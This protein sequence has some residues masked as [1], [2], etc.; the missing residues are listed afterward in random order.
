M[1]YFK[2]TK[3]HV[4]IIFLLFSLVHLSIV[5]LNHYYYKTFTFDYGVYNFA[6]FDFAHLRVS[7]CPVYLAG[8]DITFLQDH[9]SLTLIFL[10]PLYWLLSPVFGTY[11]LLIIQWSLILLGGWATY[12]YLLLRFQNQFLAL[13]AL[14]V[15]FGLYG[16]Y[17]AYQND[18]NLVTMGSALVPLFFYFFEKRKFIAVY[19]LFL[20][21]IFNR[22]DFSLNLFFVCLMLAILYR[23]DQEQRRVALI[24]TVA[25]VLC[26]IVIFQFIIPALED[27]QKSFS[28]FNYQALG[29]DPFEAFV[30]ILSH[31]FDSIVLLV[32]NHTN[33][34]ENDWVK[35]RFYAV[36]ALSGGIFLF[37]RPV[38]LIALI[39]LIAKKMYNDDS[40][41]WSIESYHGV[42]VASILPILVFSAVS[43]IKFEGLKVALAA[44]S[45]F[46]TLSLTFYLVSHPSPIY[47]GVNKFNLFSSSFYQ[48]SCDK[49][50]WNSVRKKIPDSAVLSATGNVLPHLAFRK[51]IFYF[52]QI[53]EAD[54][55]CI[56]KT[57]S[58]YP[59][60]QEIFDSRVRELRE[61]KNWKIMMEEKDCLI[62]QRLVY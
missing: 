41:R 39:P 59:V 16:R 43:Q 50:T 42:E 12:H 53:N 11:T 32:K 21:L 33:L 44:L 58:T 8:F 62:F 29:K 18:C 40:L 10:S 37:L 49:T 38:Y 17:S 13:A 24:L 1:N 26:F 7:P 20:L 45:V 3:R 28:L 57:A 30:F 56:S 23:K 14:I 47:Y 31:P 6:F 54:F 36:Y 4:Y 22:E 25:S 15:Y 55:V 48:S 52:P 51:K 61:S 5:V 27:A 35:F 9:F 19:L 2:S 46:T 60:S 34:A